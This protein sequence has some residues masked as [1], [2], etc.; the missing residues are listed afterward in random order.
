MSKEG[1]HG[2]HAAIELYTRNRQVTIEWLEDTTESRMKQLPPSTLVW[3]ESPQN[4]RGEVADLQYY[5]SNCPKSVIIAVDATFAPPPLQN[6]L[7]HGADYV[8]HSS[9]KFLGGH[10]DLLGGVLMTK[11]NQ[12][13]SKLLQDRT[14]LGA[15]MGSMEAWLLLRSVRTLKV[16]VV[17]QSQSAAFLAHWLHSK[18]EP[19]LSIVAKVW[20]ASLP[21][22]PGH[23]ASKRQGNGWSG[24]L[25]IEFTSLHHARL[26]CSNLELF[27]NATS[28]GGCES[29]IEWR[30]AVDPKI[31]PTLCRVNIGLEAVEDLQSDLRQ[32]F[33]KVAELAKQYE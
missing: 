2:S 27:D 18:S 17:Q 26:I 31:S 28:L 6:L 14:N 8:M 1:Y 7:S 33:L 4:P 11:E 13:Y 23:E 20:H 30:A 5:R 16:R 29:L 12:H 21:D 9:T 24:V 25:A 32:G 3:L 15:V 22:H 10:S 19:C